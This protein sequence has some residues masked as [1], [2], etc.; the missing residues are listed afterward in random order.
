[1]PGQIC[2]LEVACSPAP[3][4]RNSNQVTDYDYET[5]GQRRQNLQSINKEFNVIN[6]ICIAQQ[7]IKLEPQPKCNK[8]LLMNLLHHIVYDMLQ[9]RQG[10]LN[11]RT[12]ELMTAVCRQYL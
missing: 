1:M 10:T 7:D 5:N 11:A 9:Q 4:D 3:V 8:G 6:Q 2:L 12:D